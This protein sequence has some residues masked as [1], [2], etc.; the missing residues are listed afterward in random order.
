MLFDDCKV[1]LLPSSSFPPAF[2]PAP[3]PREALSTS[4]VR[5]S[6]KSCSVFSFVNFT[7]EGK[8]AAIVVAVFEI[9]SMAGVMMAR[10]MLSST[11]NGTKKLSLLSIEITS[12]PLKR[13][14]VVGSGSGRK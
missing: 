2:P 5:W 14:D 1:S 6:R 7:I 9:S 8:I 4:L 13:L 3:A 12:L 11:I 10:T